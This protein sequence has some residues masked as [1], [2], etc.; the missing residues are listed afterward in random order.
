MRKIF[1]LLWVFLIVPA[2]A[3]GP[4]HNLKVGTVQYNQGAWECP[5]CDL[6]N[7][8]ASR[9]SW[10]ISG[11]ADPS[12]DRRSLWWA[13]Y[14]DSEGL[15]VGQFY[16]YIID[17]AEKNRWQHEDMLLHYDVDYSAKSSWMGMDCFDIFEQS[18]MPFGQLSRESC[19]TAIHGV[20]LQHKKSYVDVTATIYAGNCGDACTIHNGTNLLVGY[21]EPFDRI[22]LTL[23]NPRSGGT[24][25]WRY[26]NGHS[27]TPVAVASDETSG[28]RRNGT[29]LLTP[30]TDWQPLSV[31]GSHNKFWLQLEVN[32]TS[33]A[34]R[35]GTLK[36]DSWMN[37]PDRMRGWNS[38][39]CQSALITL[40]YQQT[41]YCAQP[42]TTGPDAASARWRYQSRLNAYANYRNYI[43]FNPSNE[44]GGRYSFV[45]ELEARWTAQ[46]AHSGLKV[47]AVFLDNVGGKPTLSLATFEE[48]RTDLVCSPECSRGS[49]ATYFLNYATTLRPSLKKAF[50]ELNAVTANVV[51]LKAYIPV[52]DGIMQELSA[53]QPYIGDFQNSQFELFDDFLP[54]NNRGGAVGLFS[55][56]DNVHFSMKIG[57]QGGE[58][59]PTY[60][61]VPEGSRL[62]MVN[63]AT[64][65]IASNA[66]T[67]LYYNT[68]GWSY[69]DTDEFYVFN[70]VKTARLSEDLAAGTTAGGTIKLDNASGF[71]PVG[72]PL[73]KKIYLVRIGGEDVA[74][75][76]RN[77]NVFTIV[78]ENGTFFASYI[79]NSYPSG[80]S[81]EFAQVE[82]WS[83]PHHAVPTKSNVW[84]YSNWWPA[85]WVDI[86]DPN[87]NGWRSGERDISYLTGDA[88]STYPGGCNSPSKCAAVWRR[89]FTGYGGTVILDR[90]FGSITAPSELDRPGLPILLDDPARKLFGPYYVLQAD[91]SSSGP[92]KSV[93]L[94]ADEAVIL[95]KRPVKPANIR[96]N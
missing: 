30:P 32:G 60:H 85:L 90:V 83:D 45:A 82:H 75:C 63:L 31:N 86:G 19:A 79:V 27:W 68:Q 10:V 21:A 33:E 48:N 44:Q 5:G 8:L 52:F 6:P 89:D 84:Y 9:F 64:Y 13:D 24:V 81:V 51:S 14:L 23:G 22:D 92:V 70:G 93:S 38:R 96:G 43:F 25:S 95:T 35:I 41:Q 58:R 26:W 50:P 65:Y 53:S 91:G 80:T 55:L 4:N 87:P 54:T 67:A 36:G 73:Y 76:T 56:W 49:W 71:T 20:F 59:G 1:Q 7:A 29:L 69:F 62:N 78:P 37:A 16:N 42:M 2:T 88:A 15:Y 77:G 46:R 72:G 40:E 34:P 57:S 18:G 66:D 47:N 3:Q 28:L 11:K 17:V 39:S 61:I 74:A 94:R 12:A